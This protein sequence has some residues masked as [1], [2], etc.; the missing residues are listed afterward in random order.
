MS[1]C[2]RVWL[3]GFRSGIGVMLVMGVVMM[4][5]HERVVATTVVLQ[6]GLYCMCLRSA[7]KYVFISVLSFAGY[8]TNPLYLTPIVAFNALRPG[9]FR[10]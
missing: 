7:K 9:I 6:T 8:L 10:L 3:R 2:G 4:L 1:C 5:R